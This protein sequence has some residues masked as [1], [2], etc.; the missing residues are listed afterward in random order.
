MRLP[1]NAVRI[2]LGW[3]TVGL[4]VLLAAGAVEAALHGGLALPLPADAEH[5]SAST[6][7]TLWLSGLLLAGT[8]WLIAYARS[9]R[10]TIDEAILEPSEVAT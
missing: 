3:E 1:G 7:A 4:N 10:E 2:R 9:V 8:Y 6:S 5:A